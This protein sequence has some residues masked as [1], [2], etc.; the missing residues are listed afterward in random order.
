MIADKKWTLEVLEE[1]RKILTYNK[2]A[3]NILVELFKLYED[4][5]DVLLL[6]EKQPQLYTILQEFCSDIP[7]TDEELRERSKD[8]VKFFEKHKIE[9][10][11]CDVE[12]FY[13]LLNFKDMLISKRIFL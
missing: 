4:E 1:R 2:S 7:S 13:A 12:L 10:R 6:K 3:L 5:F 11:Q 8:L 9:I